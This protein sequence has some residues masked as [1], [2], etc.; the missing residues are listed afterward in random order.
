[1]DKDIHMLTQPLLTEEGFVNEACINELESHIQNM[2]PDWERLADDPEWSTK[3]YLRWRDITG[4]LANW[5][6]RNI[7]DN[8]P[9]PYPP[10]LES[11][12]GYLNA[13][14]RPKFDKLGYAHFTL[15]EINKML[16][17]ILMPE[18]MFL[19]WND[20]KIIKGWL[21]LDALIR[22][23]CLSIRDEKRES[24]RF[25]AKFEKENPC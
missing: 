11:V 9:T 12:I 23:V 14:I 19:D 10:K 15:C 24:D 22:N 13:C 5:A 3:I 7:S 8:D 2:P 25:H 21:D 6:I 20:S 1:M 16:H 17:E 18:Q 4:Y